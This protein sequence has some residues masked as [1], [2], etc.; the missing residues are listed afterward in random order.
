MY[1]KNIIL[2]LLKVGGLVL[3]KPRSKNVFLRLKHFVQHLKYWSVW[4][5]KSF[6]LVLAT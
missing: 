3:K 6:R 5:F 4:D 1:D 2:N